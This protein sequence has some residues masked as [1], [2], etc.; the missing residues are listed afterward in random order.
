MERVSV[1]AG[2]G[3]IEAQAGQAEWIPWAMR[4]P[5]EGELGKVAAGPLRCRHQPRMRGGTGAGGEGA[6]VGLG[7]MPVE[8]SRVEL[9][10]AVDLVDVAVDAVA[11]GDVDEAV[12]PALMW[13]GGGSDVLQPC[14]QREQPA[15]SI[16]RRSIGPAS[17][18]PAP[19]A[20]RAWRA[21][22]SAGTA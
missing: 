3:P 21:S 14:D 17:D 20:P 19:A 4:G 10:E 2:A 5:A 18:H 8:G 7:E 11:D 13:H 22:S 12:V 15:G 9:G 6:H 1:E 16:D